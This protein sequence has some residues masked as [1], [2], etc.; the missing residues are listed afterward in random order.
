MQ[1]GWP[2]ADGRIPSV[3]ADLQRQMD[4]FGTFFLAPSQEDM[5]G[6]LV[7]LHAANENWQASSSTGRSMD[8]GFVSRGI[9]VLDGT[10]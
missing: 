9:A 2:Y 3:G 8:P 1:H 6:M 10:D 5:A 4:G 7:A